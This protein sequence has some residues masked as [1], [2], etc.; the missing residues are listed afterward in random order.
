MEWAP[1]GMMVHAWHACRDA[2]SLL[3]VLAHWNGRAM[4]RAS[5]AVASVVVPI[6]LRADSRPRAALEAAR[7]WAE[8]SSVQIED[9]A[10]L[11]REASDVTGDRATICAARAAADSAWAARMSAIGDASAAADAAAAVAANAAHAMAAS[12]RQVSRA[13]WRAALSGALARLADVV[14]AAAPC[15]SLET[16]SRAVIS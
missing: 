1:D 9:L 10:Q 2:Q 13:A 16:L 15:P 3:R 8:G 14:R 12:A 6:A 7:R 5:C 4:V 11:A